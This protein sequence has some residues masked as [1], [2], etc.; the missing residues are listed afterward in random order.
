MVA[1]VDPPKGWLYGFPKE[2]PDPLPEGLSF[3]EWLMSE[4]Y[5]KH[6][7]EDPDLYCWHSEEKE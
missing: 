1:Y 4:G 7:A 2:L 3:R 5:P 6:L